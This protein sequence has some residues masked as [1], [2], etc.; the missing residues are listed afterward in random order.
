MQKHKII[1]VFICVTISL[2]VLSSCSND[3]SDKYKKYLTKNWTTTDDSESA[4]DVDGNGTFIT[5]LSYK[6]SKNHI[7]VVEAFVL[8]M[9][10]EYANDIPSISEVRDIGEYIADAA[11]NFSYEES[12]DYSQ[13]LI[14]LNYVA[15]SFVYSPDGDI[16]FVP[17]DWTLMVDA[18]KRFR[19]VDYGKIQ[20]MAGGLNFL[21]KNGVGEENQGEFQENI[22]HMFYASPFISIGDDGYITSHNLTTIEVNGNIV[23]KDDMGL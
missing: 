14:H 5:P 6:I 22:A 16:L 7:V 20:N 9:N 13:L 18:Y 2:F 17:E 21:V 19:T 1:I 11:L 12:I 4:F 3:K 15:Y 10:I 8:N 23:T